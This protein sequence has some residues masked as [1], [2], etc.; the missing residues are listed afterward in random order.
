M[1]G[2]RKMA[3][4]NNKYDTYDVMSLYW[5]YENDKQNGKP[6]PGV[7]VGFSEDG[8]ALVNK[9]TTKYKNKSSFIKL[10]Y[11]P[12]KNMEAAGL[13]RASYIDIKSTR[14]IKLRSL[15]KRGSL[16][17]EDIIDL[18]EFKRSYPQRKR[19]LAM[20]IERIREDRERY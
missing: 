4:T 19:E 11:Y 2:T 16:A 12:I 17:I 20:K 14:K 10:Q 18:A 1:N 6:R 13:S 8:Q 9:T 15:K 5:F 3:M 7:I